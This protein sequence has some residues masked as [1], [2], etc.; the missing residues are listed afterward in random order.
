MRRI[1][2]VIFGIKSAER[3]PIKRSTSKSPQEQILHTQLPLRMSALS[4]GG[5]RYLSEECGGVGISDAGTF[6]LECINF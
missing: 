6:Q 1:E 3:Y 2:V 4:I 5:R